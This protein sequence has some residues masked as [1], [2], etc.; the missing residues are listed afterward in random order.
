MDTM[1]RYNTDAV[2]LNIKLNLERVI[3]KLKYNR[4]HCGISQ[5]EMAKKLD[6]SH[7]K[8]QRI[9]AMESTPSLAMLFKT[10]QLLKIK[11]NELTSPNVP[12]ELPQNF[13]VLLNN[14]DALKEQFTSLNESNYF[15]ICNSGE[16]ENI[17]M[18]NPKEIMK[19]SSFTNSDFPLYLSDYNITYMNDALRKITNRALEHKPTYQGWKDKKT[20]ARVWDFLTCFDIKYSK[21]ITEIKTPAG[22]LALDSL[23]RTFKDS[24]GRAYVFGTF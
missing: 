11:F 5:A 19:L 8:Y 22:D 4:A 18:E 23:N 9:E 17:I 1:E 2:I 10:S 15:E 12:Q 24:I 7:R 20:F 3:F 16:I 13:Q 21:V 6:M 14:E